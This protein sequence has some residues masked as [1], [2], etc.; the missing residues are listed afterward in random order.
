MVWCWVV[1]GHCWSPVRRFLSAD[2]APNAPTP[3]PS[4]IPHSPIPHTPIPPYPIPHPQGLA[5]ANHRPNGEGHVLPS[6][7]H[8]SAVPVEAA[9]AEPA[10]PRGA[11]DGGRPPL[12]PQRQAAPVLLWGRHRQPHRRPPDT[13]QS[14]LPVCPAQWGPWG[15]RTD[16]TPAADPRAG[17]GGHCWPPAVLVLLRAWQPCQSGHAWCVRAVHKLPAQS[18][19]APGIGLA[20]GWGRLR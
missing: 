9:A 10:P 5:P 3:P 1:K 17:S 8:V 7:V 2:T 14:I 16:A 18:H 13:R 6:A 4:P 19:A 11:A 20:A 15:S 12:Q